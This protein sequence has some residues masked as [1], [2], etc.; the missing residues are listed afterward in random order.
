MKENYGHVDTTG[1]KDVLDNSS[2][3]KKW[4]IK[5]DDIK[6][7]MDCEFRYICPDCRAFKEQPGDEFSKPLKCGY[8]PYTGEWRRN[9]SHLPEFV[10]AAE[11]YERG[12]QRGENT[13]LLVA[14]DAYRA[15]L[16]ERTRERVPLDWAMT[17]NNLGA[18]LATLAERES[19]TA[20]LEEAVAAY[21]AALEEWTPEAAFDWHQLAQQNLERCLTSLEQRRKH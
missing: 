9:K 13:A 18:V 6:V 12:D 5:K 2:F 16:E 17:Q 1:F 19:G 8:D 15:A 11:F 21:R 10:K 7:C 3:T 4:K 20:H 14:V